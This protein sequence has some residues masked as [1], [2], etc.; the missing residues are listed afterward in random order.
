M[1]YMIFL[2]LVITS[3]EHIVIDIYYNCTDTYKHKQSRGWV[4]RITQ[5]NK[6]HK[7]KLESA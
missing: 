4:G 6:T 2:T 5:I 1:D 3:T 7:M